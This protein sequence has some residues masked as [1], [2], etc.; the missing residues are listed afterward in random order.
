MKC[1]SK[2]RLAAWPGL[3]IVLFNEVNIPLGVFRSPAS[4]SQDFVFSIGWQPGGGV[5]ESRYYKYPTVQS[6]LAPG[7]HYIKDWPGD[8]WW[9]WWSVQCLGVRCEV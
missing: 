9:W 6:G 4:S 5:T 7:L 8:Q 1:N 3:L 2:V